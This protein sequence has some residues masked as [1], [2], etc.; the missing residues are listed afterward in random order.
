LQDLNLFDRFRQGL[1]ET[2]RV[3]EKP[4]HLFNPDDFADLLS[5]LRLVLYFSWGGYLISASGNLLLEISHDDVGWLYAVDPNEVD[6][7]ALA[8]LDHLA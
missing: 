6:V 5:L 2:A 3:W 7:E 4:G 1:G 8:R